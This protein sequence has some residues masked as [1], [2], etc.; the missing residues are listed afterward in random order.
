MPRFLRKFWPQD[1]FA[2]GVASPF[3]HSFTPVISMEHLTI[4]HS[5]SGPG[6]QGRIR[7]GSDKGSSQ[8]GSSGHTVKHREARDHETDKRRK[9]ESFQE[10][11]A[12]AKSLWHLVTSSVVRE[13]WIFI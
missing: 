12:C 5:Q 8:A 9:E 1:T 2:C 7:E 6:L 11:P 13:L 10:G 4:S 3:T